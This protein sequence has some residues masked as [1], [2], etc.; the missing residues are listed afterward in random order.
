[1]QIA[2]LDGDDDGR[3]FKWRPGDLYGLASADTEWV[4]KA[5]QWKSYEIIADNGPQ[6]FFMNRHPTIDIQMWSDS[7]RTMIK[8]SKFAAGPP[9]GR[10]KKNTCH[11]R[12]LK[13]ANLGTGTSK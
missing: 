3:I 1:M 5:G 11:S 13:R 12:E 4:K 10:P 2:D 8:R 7:W 9:R 6:T